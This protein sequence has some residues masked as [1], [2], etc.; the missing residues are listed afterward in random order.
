MLMMKNK[1]LRLLIIPGYL[2]GI[3]SLFI[4]TYRT[5]LAFFSDSKA[6]TIYVN[7]YGEQYADIVALI[8]IWSI[9]LIGLIVLYFVVKDCSCQK[10]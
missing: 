3:G 5:L 8:L 7:K 9:C 1:K 2:V 10:S 6:V 4:V